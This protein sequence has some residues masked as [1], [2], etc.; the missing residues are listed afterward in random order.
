VKGT[1]KLTPASTLEILLGKLLPLGAVFAF[2]VVLMLLAA[3]FLMGVWPRGS[4]LLFIAISSFY[5]LFSLALGLIFSA[6]SATAAEAVQKTVLA[7]IPTI[8]LSGFAFPIRSTPLPIQWFAELIPA[9][10]YI[11]VSRAIYLRGAGLTELLPEIAFLLVFGA[12]LLAL[13]LRTLERRA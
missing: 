1:S 12:I 10:H 6:T 9:T 2:D 8:Q 3:G 13:A 4:A 7:S 5:V 11:R